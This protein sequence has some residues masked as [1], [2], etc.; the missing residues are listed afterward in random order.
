MVQRQHQARRFGRGP[1]HEHFQTEP[2]VPAMHERLGFFDEM[3]GRIPDQR[4]IAEDVKV[5]CLRV[6][7]L[8]GIQ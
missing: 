3:E 4:A 2:P 5:L 1:P 8:S 7:G 6:I